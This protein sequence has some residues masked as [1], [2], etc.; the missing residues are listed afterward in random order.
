MPKSKSKSPLC[1]CGWYQSDSPSPYVIELH[2]AVVGM[3]TPE[4]TARISEAIELVT[5]YVLPHECESL[6]SLVGRHHFQFQPGA[7][8]LAESLDHLIAST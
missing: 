7:F 8:A 6:C 2:D 4:G 5:A 1:E 3:D